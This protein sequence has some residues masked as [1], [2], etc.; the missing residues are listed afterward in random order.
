[1]LARLSEDPKLSPAQR[2]AGTLF[3]AG[4]VTAPWSIYVRDAVGQVRLTMQSQPSPGGAVTARLESAA[5]RAV[6]CG[7]GPAELRIGGRA[8]DL[9]AAVRDHAALSHALPRGCASH[10]TGARRPAV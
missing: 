5:A 4:H 8:T 3:H 9:R 6:W 7:H 1:M 10:Q 2:E